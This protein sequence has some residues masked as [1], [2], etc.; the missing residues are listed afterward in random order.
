MII[1]TEKWVRCDCSTTKYNNVFSRCDSCG[2]QHTLDATRCDS[3][4][5]EILPDLYTCSKCGSAFRISENKKISGC[6]W[7]LVVIVVILLI[8]L[9]TMT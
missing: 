2:A 4:F 3:C 8:N 5:E 9:C 1:K 7:V 6:G